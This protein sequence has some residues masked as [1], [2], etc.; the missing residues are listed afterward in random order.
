MRQ[1]HKGNLLS[2]VIFLIAVVVTAA[3]VADYGTFITSNQQ[4][5]EHRQAPWHH[6]LYLPWGEYWRSRVH[7]V[8]HNDL[9]RDLA[10][11][12]LALRIVSSDVKSAAA[13]PA[14]PIAGRDVREIRVCTREGTELLWAAYDPNM[15]PIS[16]GPLPVEGWL[17]VPIACPASATSE[18]FV[19]FD[20]PKAG[21]VPDYFSAKPR[22]IN[23]G[24]EQG[25]GPTP[26]GWQHDPGDGERRA[27]WSDENPHSG[28]KCLAI[29]VKPGAKPSWIATRQ[30]NI[31][32]IPGARYRLQAWVRAQDVEG[33]AGWY[34]HV[35]NE[36]NEMI[37]A[38]TI[39]AGEGTYEWKLVETE[40]AAPDTA[41]IASIGTVLWGT[42]HAWFDDVQWDELDNKS[43]RVTVDPVES[44]ALSEGDLLQDWM[45]GGEPA[46]SAAQRLHLQLLNFEANPIQ[47][48]L[49]C[50]NA[51]TLGGRQS[52]S[53]DLGCPGIY[54]GK[55]SIHPFRVGPFLVWSDS[56][57]PKSRV[58]RYIYLEDVVSAERKGQNN[59][60]D[61]AL[62]GYLRL[63][64]GEKNLVRNPS[65]ETG[66]TA[67][68]GWM[69]SGGSE[70]GVRFSVDSATKDGLGHRAA[71]L[72]VSPGTRAAW[73]GWQQKIAVKPGNTY[74]IAGWL[75]C[76]ELKSAAQIHIHFHDRQ[77]Q[78]V[79]SGGMTSVGPGVSGTQDWTL[80]S[81]LAKV[82]KDATTLTLHLTMN[83][84]GTL[85]HDGIV[86]AE[87]IT[88]SHV[89][90]EAAPLGNDTFVAWQVPSVVKVFKEDPPVLGQR[91]IRASAA[92]GEWEAIQLAVRSGS[93]LPEVQV[94][95]VPPRC[96]SQ[97][98]LDQ[99]DVAVVGYVPI[100]Y[101]T[102]YY[103]FDGPEWHR[104]L[105]Q[106]VPGSDGW[107]GWWPDPLLPQRQFALPAET[108]QAVWIIFRI[109]Q[110]VPAGD[111]QGSVR[112]R[113]GE[114]I[115]TE[116]PLTVHVW[117]FALPQKTTFP[118]IYDVRL[119][120]G[121]DHWG[122][123]FDELYP[124]IVRFMAERRLCPDKI[125]PDPVIEYRDGRVRADFSEYDKV[126]QWYFGELGLPVTYS[127]H[128][129]YLFGWGF[130]PRDFLGET[131]YAGERPFTNANRR[132]LRP[133]YKA[134][135]QACLKTYW[136]HMKQQGWSQNV[137][138]YISDE[139][140]DHLPE[141]REQ[142][143]A[144][145][146]M[147]RE[148]DPQIPIYS[149]TWHHVPDW[150]GS[151]TLWGL[152]H[153]G[154]VPPEKLRALREDGANVWFTTDGQMCT[155]T[156]YCAVERLLPHYCFHHGV[157]A[158]EFW[159]V[160]WTTYDPYRFG[161]HSFIPQSD[162]PDNRYWVRYPNGDG[163]LIYPGRPIGYSGLVSSIRLEQAREGVED[164]EYLRLLK[165]ASEGL[166]ITDPGRQRAVNIL[167]TAAQLVP[168]P[169]AG[170]RYSTKILPNPK[171]L[172]EIREEVAQ[173]IEQILANK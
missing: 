167:A 109:P 58:H 165:T 140:F 98:R 87:M 4:N 71:R 30:R 75:R 70:Q 12:P 82:P 124:E 7:L 144:L 11:Y 78:L 171:L 24:M 159:G 99:Y 6:P 67:P 34:V 101:P 77:G 153:D 94:E 137:V 122:K 154:R 139:P 164:Y 10:G 57:P 40:F 170:G 92:K 23:C 48:L 169:N 172:D 130:P 61:E 110:A 89:N 47:S 102:N 19:Y 88:V 146:E 49:V 158:Y 17:V 21:E 135:Y 143:I 8:Y 119:G 41:T 123:T 9:S 107:A 62:A 54:A 56:L 127:P 128:M 162:R 72:D 28:K 36:E 104:K 51:S 121:R 136:E 16:E 14:I 66:E 2:A 76:Q 168:I 125:R 86:V 93:S 31:A 52:L 160:A 145:C 60:F 22:P 157:S 29:E 118:A 155:D 147:I 20:N 111:Y 138:L 1:F 13:S 103:R 120:P 69:P 81:G 43:Q 65:F 3:A 150:D 59:R 129:F 80:V 32:V 90:K 148:V 132:H 38:P 73:R 161:W 142:M 63:L 45:A 112:F 79:K 18:L 173:A 25:E 83:T 126:A 42:G 26:T 68:E 152:G 106:G 91:S 114:R 44:C 96:E 27:Y 133:E 116:I 151:I 53:S 50:V 105:P 97:E 33:Y 113:K 85:W 74:L 100:D 115:L 149:S 64:N 131:P 95:V 163:F 166:P 46:K 5:E 15:A 37:I 39:S 141:I 84:T 35:G 55:N 108:T 156:P 117:D 134:A